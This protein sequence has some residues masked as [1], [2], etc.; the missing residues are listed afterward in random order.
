MP[1]A[2]QKNEKIRFVNASVNSESWQWVFEGGQPATSTEM[3]PVVKYAEAGTYKVTL[4]A[5]KGAK[6]DEKVI[7]SYITVTSI[8]T[9]IE[10]AKALLLDIYPNPTRES[11]IITNTGLIDIKQISMRDISGKLIKII[12]IRA[13]QQTGK[14][15]VDASGLKNG[16]YLIEIRTST[17]VIIKR[18]V[19]SH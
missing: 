8:K 1:M 4:I 5:S 19:M 11:F 13:L 10:T 15:A 16:L 6:T 17:S 12:P 18:V 9:G 14:Y 7:E 2:K 3:H